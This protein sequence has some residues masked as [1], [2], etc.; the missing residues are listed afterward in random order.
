MKTWENYSAYLETG[1]WHIHTSHTDGLS[2]VEEYCQKAMELGIP[3]LAFTEHVRH[4]LNYNFEEL[5]SEIDDAKEKFP[6]IIILSGCEAKVLPDGTLDVDDEILNVVDYPVFAY[7]SF[8]KDVPLI[9]NTVLTVIRDYPIN[10][11]AHPGFF[12]QKHN[13]TL[14]NDDLNTIFEEMVKSK[15]LL[16]INRKYAVPTHQWLDLAKMKGVVT[17]K[18]SDCHSAPQLNL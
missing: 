6:D 16:E 17:V 8:P 1:E 13:L 5:L 4:S 2:T 15:I 12:I 7:H 18:G 11:W 9:V 10:A 3:L 14:S